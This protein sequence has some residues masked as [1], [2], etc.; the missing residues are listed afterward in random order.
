[1]VDP[2]FKIGDKV[3]AKR[4]RKL[5]GTVDGL[6]LWEIDGLVEVKMDAGLANGPNRFFK[7]S[8]LNAVA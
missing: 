1:M 5:T 8:D 3:I 6:Q 2:L 7:E 4:N